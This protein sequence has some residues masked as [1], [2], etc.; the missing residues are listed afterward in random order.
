MEKAGE[1]MAAETNKN[2][3]QNETRA[4]YTDHPFDFMTGEDER[5]IDS[6]QPVPFRAFV[7]NYLLPGQRVADV[8]CGPGRATLYLEKAGF[9][10][11]A[12]DLSLASLDLARKRAGNALFTCASNLSM[13]F[14]PE[15]FDAVISDG[16]IHHTPDA[17]RSF[18]ENAKLVRVGGYLYV[19]VYK[20]WRYYYYI[21]N[22]IGVPVR[23]LNRRPWGK[24]LVHATLL[25]VY[26]LAHLVKSGGTRTWS[27]AKNLFYDYI[28][29][30]RAT[31]HTREE[32][33]QWGAEV[34]LEL[35][36]Y[37]RKNIGNC[38]AFVFRKPA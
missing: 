7:E 33:V 25:P 22:H 29:T 8:G 15:S 35:V 27:G 2:G 32:I 19:A 24:G 20:R 31:F 38:H 3:L 16:V 21:Y 23:W 10:V 18:S 11:F 13:P 36:H 1:S 26:Y 6:L 12:V 4:H 5:V 30:P 37:E 34:G 14:R 17:H 28:I 9:K